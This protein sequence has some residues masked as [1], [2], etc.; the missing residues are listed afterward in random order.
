MIYKIRDLC[1][2]YNEMNSILLLCYVRMLNVPL[3][4]C[5]TQEY[6]TDIITGDVYNILVVFYTVYIHTYVCKYVV[7]HASLLF[8]TYVHIYI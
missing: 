5:F 6:N 8:N 4:I 3:C 7:Y 1:Y 2:K